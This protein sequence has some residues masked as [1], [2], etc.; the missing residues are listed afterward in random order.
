[1][2]K[3]YLD[4]AATTQIREEVIREMVEVMTN[5]FGNPSSTHSFGRNAKNII[6]LSRKAIAKELELVTAD[7]KDS[8]G[9]CFIGKVS[10]PDFLQQQLKAKPGDVVEI[11]ADAEVFASNKVL[12]QEAKHPSLAELSE[13]FYYA[14]DMGKVLGQHRGAHY[15]TNGQRKGLPAFI[16][17][18]AAIAQAVAAAV[19]ARQVTR[20]CGGSLGTRETG[21]ALV[22]RLLAG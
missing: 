8:Q 1:M 12:A 5:D 13:P 4:N 3:V 10:L 17:A 2:N 20:D 15:F 18:N 19:A 9:L 22:A 21:K 6:E 7:K 16:E 14:K 11:A